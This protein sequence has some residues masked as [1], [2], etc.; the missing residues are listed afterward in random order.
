MILVDKNIKALAEEGKLIVKGYNESN[1]N[2]M[3]YDLTIAGTVTDDNKIKSNYDLR[4]G[5]VVFIKSNEQIS[6]P[7]NLMARVAEKNSRMRQGLR[8][9]GPHYQPGHTTY[10]FL[11]VQNISNATITLSKD[12]QIAQLIFEELKEVPDVPYNKQPGNSFE[13][14]E[15]YRG[16]GNYRAKYEEQTSVQIKT[17]KDEF[18]NLSQTIY[19]NILTLMGILVAIF[20]LITIN[21]SAFTKANLTIPYIAVMNLMIAMCTVIMMGIIVFLTNREVKDKKYLAIYL[22]ILAAIA[23]ATM[24]ICNCII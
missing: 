21:Y 13:G 2:S 14:E 17:A 19:S 23:F 7:M 1:V 5:E 24:T 11:R 22:A 16:L 6:M 20:S 8:V 9:D 18:A 10:C 4:P 3:S 12:S 15:E